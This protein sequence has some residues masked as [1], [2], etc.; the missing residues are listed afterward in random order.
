M[1][2]L[3]KSPLKRNLWYNT[4]WEVRP[5]KTLICQR[6]GSVQD[7]TQA[8]YKP[9]HPKTVMEANQNRIQNV[10]QSFTLY[11][12]RSEV[13]KSPRNH[14]SNFQ[15]H[16]KCSVERDK[17]SS[18]LFTVDNANSVH[19]ATKQGGLDFVKQ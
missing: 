8:E 5:L 14:V 7:A 16:G 9:Q 2:H 13:E 1:D 18:V 17:E 4:I 6:R 10:P 3:S 12:R 19:D 15:D 11:G